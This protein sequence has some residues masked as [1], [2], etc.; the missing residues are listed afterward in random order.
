MTANV[1]AKKRGAFEAITC[2]PMTEVSTK[3]KTC[4]N[5]CPPHVFLGAVVARLFL[6]K[7]KYSQ[8]IQID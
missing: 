2:P 5:R 4:D 7:N 8:Q 3:T 1:S 6:S